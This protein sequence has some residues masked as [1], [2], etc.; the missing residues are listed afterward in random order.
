M[1]VMRDITA[2]QETI[3]KYAA[4]TARLHALTETIGAPVW[5][6]RMDG[7]ISSVENWSEHRGGAPD[8]PLGKSW[9]EY[10][11]PDDKLPTLK[12]WTTA[13]AQRGTYEIE[14]RVRQPDGSYRWGLSR[15]VPARS[16][17]RQVE[18]YVGITFDIQDR[19]VLPPMAD[20][21]TRLTG[22]QIRAARGILRWSVRD[23][24]DRAH[25][26]V[27]TIRRLEDLDSNTGDPALAPISRAL[28]GGGVEFIAV[29]SGKPGVRP[30]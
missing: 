8:E 25:V 27:A 5:T 19:K 20:V 14:H 4:S 11:H 21:E 13:R 1:G 18:E 6:A 30:R 12:A 16:A 17:D 3:G 28:I 10:L 23:L 26:S 2:R 9:V 29:A 15:A 24:A 22:A 7:E